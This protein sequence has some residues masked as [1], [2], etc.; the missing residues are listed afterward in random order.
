MAFQP[1]RAGDEVLEQLRPIDL[2]EQL[3]ALEVIARVSTDRRQS[4]RGERN[5]VLEGEPPR[6]VFFGTRLLAERPDE[7]A[8][9]VP[10]P[11]G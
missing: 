4:V 3:A 7:I 10:V 2:A 9:D 8:P 6:N 11:V 1:L 5:E